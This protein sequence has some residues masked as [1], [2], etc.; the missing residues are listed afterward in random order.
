MIKGT[1]HQENITLI[2]IFAPNTRGSKYVKQQLIDIKGDINCNTII[3]RDLNTPLISMDDLSIY[4]SGML[5]SP[6]IIV[7]VL[8]SPF[9]LLTVA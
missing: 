3:A 2:N 7:L 1:L 5:R 6:T 9:R 8:I 4:V